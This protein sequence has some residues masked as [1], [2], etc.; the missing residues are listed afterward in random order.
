M[1][2]FES[3][4]RE[5][6][7]VV[8]VDLAEGPLSSV[9]STDRSELRRNAGLL[10]GTCVLLN[11][12]VLIAR[13]PL[14][15]DAAKMLAEVQEHLPK[16]QEVEHATNDCWESPAFVEAV[17]E[18]GRTQLVF[19]GI[20]TDVGVG[21]TALST[22]RAGLQAAVLVDVCGT[23]NARVEQAAWLRLQQAGVTLL[24]WSSFVGEVQREYNSPPGPELLRLI[25][26]STEGGS[27]HER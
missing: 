27:P 26:R 15:G 3:L 22:I 1:A 2:A 8:L 7:L 5:S 12:P 9:R 13:A 4:R 21:L 24:G 11:V 16:A 17:R 25:R 6:V 10:A 23:L 18:S 19:A 14:P 20:A